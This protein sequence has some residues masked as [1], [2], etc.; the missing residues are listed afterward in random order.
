MNKTTQR[1]QSLTIPTWSRRAQRL[2]AAAHDAVSGAIL[3]GD[4][5]ALDGAVR[6]VD[7]RKAATDYDHRDYFRLLDVEPVC[8]P[9]N[10]KRGQGYPL[11]RSERPV[12][13]RVDFCTLVKDLNGGLTQTEIANIVGCSQGNI[14][15]LIGHK[16]SQPKWPVGDALIRLHKSM[17]GS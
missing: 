14:A 11:E 17:F 2:K 16:N 9:C 3:R 15:R 10:I 1:K 4:L 5:A 8:K 6:C 7:C 12:L 13:V